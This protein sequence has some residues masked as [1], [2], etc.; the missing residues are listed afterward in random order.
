MNKL[1][2]DNRTELT[3]LQAVHLVAEVI[4]QGRISNYWVNSIV[5]VQK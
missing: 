5:M 3:D 2:I 1:I 4:K